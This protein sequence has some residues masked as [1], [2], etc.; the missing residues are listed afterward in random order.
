MICG[1]RFLPLLAALLFSCSVISWAEVCFTDEEYQ[2]L[3]QIF[4]EL[5]GINEERQMQVETLRTDLQ[6][7]KEAQTRLNKELVGVESSLLAVE[8]SLA[9]ER[10]AAAIK[11][12]L[13][14]VCA[15]VVGFFVG[16]IF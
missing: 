7:S 16:L 9:E 8:S 3:T 11:T 14:A 13:A 10:K 2:E 4:D 12:I 15:L 5:E 6:A 1:R